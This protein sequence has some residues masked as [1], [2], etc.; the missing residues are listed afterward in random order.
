M[1][2]EEVIQM[3]RRKEAMVMNPFNLKIPIHLYQLAVEEALRKLAPQERQA[4][5]LRFLEARSI[6]AVASSLGMSWE[7]ADV[8]IDRAVANVRAFLKGSKYEHKE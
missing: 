7:G 5:E 2:W 8:L 1:R 6:A 3:R 4:I